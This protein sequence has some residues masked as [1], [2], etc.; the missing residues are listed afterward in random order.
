ML[1]LSLTSDKI[2]RNQGN[3]KNKINI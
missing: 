1:G 3:I 2:K